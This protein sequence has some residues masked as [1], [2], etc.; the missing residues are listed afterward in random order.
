ME[1]ELVGAKEKELIIN[2]TTTTNIHSVLAAFYKPWGKRTKILCDSQIFSS[3]RYA[4]EA[5]IMTEG[6][7]S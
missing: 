2:G 7:G 1:E 6:T 4:V 5:Q 3:D